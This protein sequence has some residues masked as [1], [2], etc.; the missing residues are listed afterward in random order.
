M[1][2]WYGLKGLSA[3]D[4]LAQYGIA[5][6]KMG[7]EYECYAPDPD[8]DDCSIYFKTTGVYIDYY[9]QS[10]PQL[11]KF[12]YEKRI[13]LNDF[14]LLG[15]PEKIHLL[16]DFYNII[17]LL[18]LNVDETYERNRIVLD[19]ASSVDKDSEDGEV[20]ESME[21]RVKTKNPII[22]E[23]FSDKSFEPLLKAIQTVVEEF[24]AEIVSK[25]KFVNILDDYH[26][27]KGMPGVKRIFH[28][29]VNNRFI[30]DWTDDNA[31]ITNAFI[32][33]TA[34]S[35]SI[36]YGFNEDW[37]KDSMTAIF[38]A[39]GYAT[40]EATPK[41]EPKGIAKYPSEYFNTNNSYNNKCESYKYNEI[42]KDSYLP[43]RK[44]VLYSSDKKAL[45][46]KGD[47]SQSSYSIRQGTMYVASNAWDDPS[48]NQITEI[49][50]FIPNSIVAIGSC[51]FSSVCIH[52]LEIPSSV[53]FIDWM[54][55]YGSKC[56]NITLNDGLEYIGN[57][58]FWG[59]NPVRIS[60]PKT[61]KY[62]G[63]DAFPKGIEIV[64]QSDFLSVKDGLIYNREKTLL[65]C[66]TSQDAVIHLSD[67]V[68]EI[69][70]DIFAYNWNL[71]HIE[72]GGA[73]K[74]IDYRAFS[75][76]KKL[77]SIQLPES[78]EEIGDKAFEYCEE[79]YSLEIPS[80][81]KKIGSNIFQGCSSLS[82]VRC[83]SPYFEIVDDAL[84]DIK[85]KKL[86]AY[87]GIDREYEV[88]RGTKIIGEYAF[89]KITSLKKLTL[90]KSVNL[91]ESWAFEGCDKIEEIRALN[92]DC[93]FD[94]YCVDDDDKIVKG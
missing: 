70:Q 52:N 39:Q 43:D 71:I 33:K 13:T 3:E 2:K 12:M 27:F 15:I 45:V 29:I 37:V 34:K 87:F 26:A 5:V 61:L 53:K 38:V 90:P 25:S 60:L 9:L 75:Y 17:D 68:E 10:S 94:D 32:A 89:C 66:S 59:T 76:C 8:E 50:L 63:Y 30:S 48:G 85:K 56:S 69:S 1:D 6:R 44:G 83:L 74:K 81:V 62:V 92:S 19:D 28:T 20:S 7:S 41:Q 77:K 36:K 46:S 57:N 78:L 67:T 23:D 42:K 88:K 80:K 91:V 64:N 14:K 21:K 4:S 55:F 16:C 35:I 31:N 65:M 11:A 49:E 86:I 54:A 72:L 79:L 24:G 58:A 73:L 40:T 51:A 84:Y 93:K 47:F 82:E 22:V 18:E